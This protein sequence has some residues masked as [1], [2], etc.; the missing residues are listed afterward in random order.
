[1]RTTALCTLILCFVLSACGKRD[2][3]HATA[4]DPCA[5]A[6]GTPPY[7]TDAQAAQACCD[8]E[9]FSGPDAKRSNIQITN[10]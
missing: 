4:A 10:H 9:R 7:Q 8:N 6:K 5:G 1:M 3:Q 2:S